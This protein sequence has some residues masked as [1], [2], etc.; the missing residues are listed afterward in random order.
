[1]MS[2]VSRRPSTMRETR[3]SALARLGPGTGQPWHENDETMLFECVRVQ[4][5]SQW[6]FDAHV[7]ESAAGELR[8]GFVPLSSASS[9][10]SSQQQAAFKGWLAWFASSRKKRETQSGAPVPPIPAAVWVRY[11]S[12]ADVLSLALW[13]RGKADCL[14][15]STVQ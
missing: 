15:A 2:R 8:S 12:T 1:M 11:H 10:S 7:L 14:P 5:G 4:D 13:K 9:S 3:A 6:V